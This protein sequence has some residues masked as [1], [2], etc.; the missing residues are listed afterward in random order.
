MFH[1]FCARHT[2]R[3][4]LTGFAV[5]RFARLAVLLGDDYF[6]DDFQKIGQVTAQRFA[7]RYW[8]SACLQVSAHNP[9]KAVYDLAVGWIVRDLWL[10]FRCGLFAVHKPVIHFQ[11]G[12]ALIV[13]AA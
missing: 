6:S 2:L 10:D 5:K 13:P 9:H 7:I 3:L 1:H 4:L 12:V 8:F 11:L